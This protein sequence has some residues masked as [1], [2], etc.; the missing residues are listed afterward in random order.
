MDLSLIPLAKLNAVLVN[1][2]C[3]PETQ[4]DHAITVVA[5]L[6]RTNRIRET[7]IRNTK[8]T[9]TTT[10]AAT[11]SVADS[12]VIAQIATETSAALSDSRAALSKADSAVGAL[13]GLV[14]QVN[15]EFAR[16]NNE[17]DAKVAAVQ[18]IDYSRV[19]DVLRSEVAGLFDQFKRTATPEQL[20]DVAA[21]VP[22]TRKAKAR[23]VF[24]VTSYQKAERTIDFGNL[25]V[26]LWD[27]PDA[28][29]VLDDYIF[30]PAHLHLSLIALGNPL[31]YNQWLAGER[32]TGKTEYVTQIAARLGRK[33][34]R[35]NFD[36]QLERAEFIGATAIE[37]GT[38]YWKAGIIAEA[39]QHAGSLI[40]LD[41]LSFADPSNLAIFH[42]IGER[43]PHR[44]LVIS[45]TGLRIPVASH[46]CFFAADNSTGFGDQSGNFAGLRDQNTAFIDR[47]PYT[48]EFDYLPANDEI[49]L[50]VKR[51]GVDP[52]A[53]QVIVTFANVARE[54]ARAGVLTQPPSLRQL[55][56]WA[57]AI[58]SGFPVDLA[59][60]NAVI[61]KFPPDCAVELQG[62]YVA[63]VNEDQLQSFL[64][65]S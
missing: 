61:N 24:P 62:V 26:D 54:K 8:V 60:T 11:G 29:V 47:F 25:D 27:D 17:I 14:S 45:E 43:S 31:P 41:E 38:S 10:A 56:A 49:D 51:T 37:N 33:L 21:L 53:A 35:V 57:N 63:T 30:N 46:V 32:G 20:A 13:Y 36:G 59:F 48:L 23:D 12:A 28:P 52:Q 39:I 9:A 5:A 50:I 40:L 42:S 22:V 4:K 16:L 18:G 58:T 15:N 34:Y 44:A 19:E 55:F 2:G 3:L 64:V 65:R 1:A 7:D 6:L